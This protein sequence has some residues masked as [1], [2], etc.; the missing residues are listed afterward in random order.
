[1]KLDRVCYTN[2]VARAGG[3]TLAEIVM[4]LGLLALLLLGSVGVFTSLFASSRKTTSTLVGL[5]FVNQKL[6][7]LA[8]SG[9]FTSTSGTEGAYVLDPN[10][11][12]QFYY[13]VVCQPLS[14]VT[15]G[16]TRYLGGYHVSIE[17]WWNAQT[18]TQIHV[19]EGLRRVK[20]ERFI[21]PRVLVP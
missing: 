10:L 20:V 12:T 17:A 13:T 7:E 4:A 16:S 21:Y 5:T 6:E 9:S 11:G 1:M 8:E 2:S 14:G 18:P 3:F 19:G 15:S